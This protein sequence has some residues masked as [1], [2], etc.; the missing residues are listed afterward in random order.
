MLLEIAGRLTTHKLNMSLR[1]GSEGLTKDQL[2]DRLQRQHL[3]LLFLHIQKW[4]HR[5]R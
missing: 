3:D 4:P 5:D 1:L 2:F